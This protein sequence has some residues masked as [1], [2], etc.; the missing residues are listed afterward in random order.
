[1]PAKLHILH[2]LHVRGEKHAPK[3]TS[4]NHCPAPPQHRPPHVQRAD[5]VGL[6]AQSKAAMRD[7]WNAEPLPGHRHATSGSR[8]ARPGLATHPAPRQWQAHHLVA[9]TIKPHHPPPTRQATTSQLSV[10]FPNHE[11]ERYDHAKPSNKHAPPLVRHPR[12]GD[13]QRIRH[14]GGSRARQSVCRCSPCI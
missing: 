8:T 11:P 12:N 14:G 4:P 7:A 2:T 6:P 9:T 5:V 13:R 10:T 3:S 1:M